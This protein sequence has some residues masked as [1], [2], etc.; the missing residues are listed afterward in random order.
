MRSPILAALILASFA[1]CSG[2]PPSKAETAAG[3]RAGQRAQ[4]LACQLLRAE[5][6]DPTTDRICAVVTRLAE[7]TAEF[8]SAGAGGQ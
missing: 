5:A 7:D 6:L 8:A 1:A 4:L 2:G 3:I